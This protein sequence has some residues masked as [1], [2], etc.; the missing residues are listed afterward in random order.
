VLNQ[1]QGFA[2]ARQ[3]AAVPI[4]AAVTGPH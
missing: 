2:A 4:A 1:T 3:K